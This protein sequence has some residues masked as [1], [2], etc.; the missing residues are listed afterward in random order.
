[1][2]DLKRRERTSITIDPELWKRAKRYCGS[3]TGPHGVRMSF[4][5]LVQSALQ[6]YLDNEGA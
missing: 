5:E 4:S 2:S 1:M 3:Q 6:Y